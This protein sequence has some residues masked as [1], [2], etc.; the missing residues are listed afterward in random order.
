MVALVSQEDLEF[1]RKHR[2]LPG[3]AAE[4]ELRAE[5]LPEPDLIPVEEVERLYAATK[6]RKE[7]GIIRWR[8][9]AYVTLKA[10]T[11]KYPADSNWLNLDTS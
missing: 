11:G 6:G 4:P 8:G 2:P 10:R 7:D 9:R 3:A 5:D 1:L